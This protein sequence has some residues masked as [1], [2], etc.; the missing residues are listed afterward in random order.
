M[1]STTR[2]LCPLE[3]AGSQRKG[4]W[5]GPRGQSG[6]VRKISLSLEYDPRTVQP[7]A[8]RYTDWA[9]LALELHVY[10]KLAVS[11]TYDVQL[12]IMESIFD[13]ECTLHFSDI[14]NVTI[15]KCTIS[16]ILIWNVLSNK[17]VLDIFTNYHTTNKCTNCMSFILKSLFKTLSLLLHVS[18]A[19]RLSSSGSTYSS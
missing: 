8:N 14:Y 5:V 15:N 17:Q 4:S 10:F 2:S 6:R 18:I 16:L 11:A 19:Y 7:V 13:I 9:I 12:W 1:N 3:W